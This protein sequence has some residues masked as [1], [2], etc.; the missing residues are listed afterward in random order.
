MSEDTHEGKRVVTLQGGPLHGQTAVVHDTQ[1]ALSLPHPYEAN[2]HCI[3]RPTLY[4]LDKWH[5][6]MTTSDSE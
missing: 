4:V 5:F 3:Y 1:T 6:Q 2:S